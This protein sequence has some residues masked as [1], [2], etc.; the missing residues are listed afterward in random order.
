MKTPICPQIARRG[1]LLL[2]G[3]VFASAGHTVNAS[4]ARSQ[5]GQKSH[6]A[7]AAD[8]ASYDIVILGGRVVDGTGNAWFH[9][10]V[11][12]RGDRIARIAPAGMLQHAAARERIDADGLVV[13]PGF[14]DIQGQSREALLF[15]DGRVVSKVTQGVTTEILGEGWT[16]APVSDRTIAV[17]QVSDP[18]AA[19]RARAFAGRTGSTPG[20]GRWSTTARRSTSA[21]SSARPRSELT[22]REWTWDRPAPLSST[23]CAGLSARRWKTALSGSPRR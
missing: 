1:L 20:S 9:G 8:S 17:T 16:N 7:D 21:R 13:C 5:A 2:V 18:E 11:A 10:D 6:D 23:R 12:L 3:V 14:I 19:N 4:D 22:S 15:G